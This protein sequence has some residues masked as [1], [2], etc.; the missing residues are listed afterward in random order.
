MILRS[1]IPGLSSSRKKERNP[2][3]PVEY[4]TGTAGRSFSGIRS[5]SFTANTPLGSSPFDLSH[6]Y[7]TLY[8]KVVLP[9]SVYDNALEIISPQSGRDARLRKMRYEFM[10]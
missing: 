5:N 6:P 1:K 4:A 3:A 2:A 9:D 7:L 8:K 10:Q